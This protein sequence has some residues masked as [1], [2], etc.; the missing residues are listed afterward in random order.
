MQEY[1]FGAAH[2]GGLSREV[3]KQEGARSETEFA[4]KEPRKRKAGNEMK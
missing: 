3:T 4:K 1:N 2:E